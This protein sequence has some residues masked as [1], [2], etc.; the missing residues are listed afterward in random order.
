MAEVRCDRRLD[1]RLEQHASGKQPRPWRRRA[2]IRALAVLGLAVLGYVDSACAQP[3]P[4]ADQ[5]ATK[6]APPRAGN[7]TSAALRAPAPAETKVVTRASEVAPTAH[8]RHVAKAK[9]NGDRKRAATTK[10]KARAHAKQAAKARAKANGRRGVNSRTVAKHAPI[11][12]T[13]GKHASAGKAHSK[14]AAKP[15]LSA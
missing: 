4:S 12:K 10:G 13:A 15:K 1:P 9:P 2:W 3:A 5:A 11:V 8:G 14:P 7:G 6:A